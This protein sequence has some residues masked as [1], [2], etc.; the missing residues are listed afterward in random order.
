MS[1]RFNRYEESITDLWIEH[2]CSSNQSL[3]KW[4]ISQQLMTI[5]KMK[6][7]FENT[8]VMAQSTQTLKFVG[9]IILFLPV[10]VAQG[11]RPAHNCAARP[12]RNYTEQPILVLSPD[13]GAKYVNTMQLFELRGLVFFI[14]FLHSLSFVL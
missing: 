14:P 1:L 4:S 10:L 7:R 9:L 6:A 13:Y 12:Q 2:S 5:T 3:F 11:R 8:I